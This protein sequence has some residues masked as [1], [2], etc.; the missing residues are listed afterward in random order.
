M[1]MADKVKL[2]KMARELYRDKFVS[3]SSQ[4]MMLLKF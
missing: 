3:D 1:I 2:V 4:K